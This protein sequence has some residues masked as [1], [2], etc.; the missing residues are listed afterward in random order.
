MKELSLYSSRFAKKVAKSRTDPGIWSERP[1][2]NDRF[3]ILLSFT[4]FGPRATARMMMETEPLKQ[5]RTLIL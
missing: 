2:N 1:F 5:F 4:R 3:Q